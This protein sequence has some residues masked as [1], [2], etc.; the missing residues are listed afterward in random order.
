MIPLSRS[1]PDPHDTLPDVALKMG[2][3]SLRSEDRALS[4]MRAAP[5]DIPCLLV[6]MVTAPKSSILGLSSLIG[7]G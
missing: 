6:V 4:T 2:S 3:S 5:S 7:L 1:K